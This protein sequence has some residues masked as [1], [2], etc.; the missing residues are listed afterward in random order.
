MLEV[1]FE[2]QDARVEARRKLFPTRMYQFDVAKA[3]ISCNTIFAQDIKKVRQ[4]DHVFPVTD[5]L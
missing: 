1:C 3:D 4:K 2:L 5:F